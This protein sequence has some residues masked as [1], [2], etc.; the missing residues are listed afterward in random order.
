VITGEEECMKETTAEELI[1][2]LELTRHPEGGWYRETYRS[3]EVIQGSALPERFTG[4]RSFSTAIIFLL[5]PGE[6]SALHRLKT[7][8]IWHFYTGAPLTVHVITPEGEYRPVKL[9]PDIAAGDRFQFVVPAGCWFGAEVAAGNAGYSLVGCTVAPG[10]DFADFEMGSRAALLKQF[11][12][13]R[14]IL[15]RLARNS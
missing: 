7:D 9:G 11:P 4:D 14:E 6:I 13:Q 12:R 2:R 3:G 1:E 8:E 15:Q 5:S 10:F